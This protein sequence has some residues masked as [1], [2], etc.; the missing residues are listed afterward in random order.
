MGMWDHKPLAEVFATLRKNAA[1]VFDAALEKAKGNREKAWEVS[2]DWTLKAFG[3]ID[4]HNHPE[5]RQ[6]R[7]E[8][9]R[10]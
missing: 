2:D 3:E 9:P 5:M 6:A 4:L 8:A 10:A 7:G 1:V